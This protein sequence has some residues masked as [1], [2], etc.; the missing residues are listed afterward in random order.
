VALFGPRDRLSV[1]CLGW[2]AA[3]LAYAVGAG[4]DWLPGQGLRFVIPVV[5]P[6]LM[7]FAA[8]VSAGARRLAPAAP[9]W[10]VAGGMVLVAPWLALSLSARA[11]IL[12]WIGTIPPLLQEISDEN[13]RLGLYLRD[14]TWPET[15]VAYHWAGTPAYYAERPGIDVFG[16]VDRHI[17]RVPAARS[18]GGALE[19]PAHARRDWDYVLKERRPDVVLTAAWGIEAHPDFR[20]HYLAARTAGGLAF[21][22]RRDATERLRDGDVQLRPLSPGG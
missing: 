5:P 3:G 8:A 4:G 22:V 9:R 16:R 1:L 10:A 20:R 2:L 15:T 13:V 7:V 18:P 6:A 11:P 17:A 19:V 14:R 21:Y 12:E